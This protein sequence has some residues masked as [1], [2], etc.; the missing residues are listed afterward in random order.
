MSG[1]QGGEKEDKDLTLTWFY[2]FLS[3][4]YSRFR[5]EAARV[6]REYEEL[7]RLLAAAQQELT[8]APADPERRVRVTYLQKRLTDLEK[9]YPWLTRDIIL[10][11]ALWGV[12]H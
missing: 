8:A 4:D 11:Y 10:E 12:P 9:K 6:E 2:D 3:E 7:R 5:Q 1:R